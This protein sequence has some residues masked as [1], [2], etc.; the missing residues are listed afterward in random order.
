MVPSE[1][2]VCSAVLLV[3]SALTGC[4]SVGKVLEGAFQRPEVAFQKLHLR[5]LSFEEVSL[6]FEFLV[7]NP[8]PVS[9]KLE[10]LDYAL[11][12][13]GKSLAQGTSAEPLRLEGKGSAPVR[14]PLTVRFVDFVDNLAILFSSRETVPYTLDAGFGL[15]TPVGPIRVPVSNEGEVPLPKVPDV[16]VADVRLANVDLAGARVEFVLDVTNRGQFPIRPQGLS[17]DLALA[18]TS[19]SR[20]EEQLPLLAANAQQQ[21]RIPLELSFL[22]LGA[23]VVEAIR[24]RSLPYAVRGE[25][26]LGVFAQPFELRGTAK[27]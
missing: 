7:T 21:V 3:T 13:D 9:V 25:L 17:Y 16:A 4:A 5:D 12:F 15:A 6:D 22:R 14:L 20:G 19:V 8:N 23:A 11:A 2:L 18:G 26:D 1:R 10:S 27:L 24:T